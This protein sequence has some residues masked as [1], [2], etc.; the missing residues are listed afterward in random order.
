M[1]VNY[2]SNIFLKFFSIILLDFCSKYRKIMNNITEIDII[3]FDTTNSKRM[4]N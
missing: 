2:P 1:E 3:R 4:S